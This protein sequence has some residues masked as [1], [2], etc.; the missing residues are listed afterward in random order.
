MQPITN[1]IVREQIRLRNESGAKSKENELKM[2]L[3]HYKGEQQLKCA[4]IIANIYKRRDD[5]ISQTRD[6]QKKEIEDTDSII[7]SYSK[8][9]K[10]EFNSGFMAAFAIAGMIGGCTVRWDAGIVG[11]VTGIVFY[12]IIHLTLS[13][14]CF[15]SL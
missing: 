11:I 4:E 9:S 2:Q 13:R 14:C 3:E 7:Y 5:E 10:P 12:T 15:R 6:K 1:S 8:K